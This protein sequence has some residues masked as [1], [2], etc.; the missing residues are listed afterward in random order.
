V[1]LLDGDEPTACL[2]RDNVAFGYSITPGRYF[3]VADTWADA[4]GAYAGP[5][6][7]SVAIR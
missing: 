7:L 5:Y 6:A 1:H 2:A 3:V 4:A